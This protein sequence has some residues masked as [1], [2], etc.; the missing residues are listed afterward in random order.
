[1]NPGL[2]T[3]RCETPGRPASAS[4]A[5][6]RWLAPLLC[7]A[8]M[9]GGCAGMQE[10]SSKVSSFGAWPEGRQPG[11]YVFERLPSQQ[12]RAREQAVLEAAAEP[13]LAAAG[14]RKA[15]D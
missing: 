15:D 11:T 1:M 5:S 9:L 12:N 2:T 10:V 13:A 3:M 7:A 14:F 4:S 8:A 6:S